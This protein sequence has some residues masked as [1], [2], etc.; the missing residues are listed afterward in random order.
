MVEKLTLHS[1]S[2]QHLLIC[3]DISY[4]HKQLT[5]LS[6]ITLYMLNFDNTVKFGKQ[7]TN[8]LKRD[9]QNGHFLWTSFGYQ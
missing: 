6:K 4:Y 2:V 3:A 7:I 5:I 1:V 9:K 8:A